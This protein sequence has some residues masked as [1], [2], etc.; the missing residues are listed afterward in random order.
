MVHFPQVDKLLY[1]GHGNDWR[2]RHPGSLEVRRR[3]ARS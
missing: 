1:D 2:T 3:V